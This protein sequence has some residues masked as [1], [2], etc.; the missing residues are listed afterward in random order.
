MVDINCNP[1]C[2]PNEAQP[3]PGVNA[4]CVTC[5]DGGAGGAAGADVEQLVLCDIDAEGNLLGT[6]IAV[7]EYDAAGNPV[8]APT[9]VDPVTGAVY[10]PQGTLQ[11]CPTG[12]CGGPLQF[13]FTSTATGPVAHPGR[14]YTAELP[15]NPGFALDSL[16]IDGT[17]YPANIQWLVTDPDGAQFATQ[18]ANFIG[19]RFPT[20]VV[21]VANPNAGTPVCGVAQPMQVDI[22]CIRIDAP[23][24]QI[25]SFQYNGGRDAI[26]N[27]AYLT[28]P[29]TDLS[30]GQFHYLRRQDAGGTLN[31][32]NTPNRGWETNDLGD[33][34]RDF[35]IWGNGPGGLATIQDT[36]P[37]PRGT[38]VQEIT[39]DINDTGPGPTI[40]QTFEVLAAGTFN[41]VLVHGARDAGEQHTIR[42]ST[43][44][45]DDVG[46]GDLINNVTFPPQVTNAGGGTPGAWTSFEQ[47]IF[48]NPGIYTF[49]FTTTNPVGPNRGGLFTDMRAFVDAPN[50]VVT[51]DNF[52]DCVIETEE[53]TSTTVCQWWQPQC[54][55]GV[56]VGWRNAETGQVMTNAAFWGQAPS[57]ECCASAGGG[58]GGNTIT[59]GNMVHNYEVCGVVG[60]IPRT[61]QRVV[62]QDQSGGVVADAFIGADGGPVAPTSW[63]MGACPVARIAE[64][65]QYDTA[66]VPICFSPDG[67][68]PATTWWTYERVRFNNDTSAEVSRVR[69]WYDPIAGVD[70]TATP[71]GVAVPCS[72]SGVQVVES[73][74]MGCA[75]GVPWSR[76]RTGFFDN[77]GALLA[78]VYTFVDSDG[79]E[80]PAAPVGFTLGAC[81]NVAEV[82][83]TTVQ[84][85]TGAPVSI[86]PA[87]DL[88]SWTVRNRD[89]TTAT[90]Q[91][92]AGA[93]LLLDNGETISSGGFNED[94]GRLND[95]IAV[96][97]GDGTV[98]VTT[99][100]R[101]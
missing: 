32:T 12:D 85:V 82:F 65:D 13:C 67:I 56:I 63:T 46:P 54:S 62:I 8:G 7:Y 9:F 80:Q 11:P 1:G 87:T 88:V 45:T 68:A 49:S 5:G 92:N 42:L 35:E 69:H 38:P 43:G 23:A 51:A 4:P 16:T 21:S 2:A 99:V 25:V 19:A 3:V 74:E 48:L 52:E 53:E 30:V 90:I 59:A 73:E 39:A 44:D 17:T 50:Q 41:L 47:S 84:D 14:R 20:A 22:S 94:G 61:L 37:T 83:Q 10:V 96:D 27:P 72:G 70:Q 101:L 76:R 71:A 86:L 29:P 55:N 89:A 6:A 97:P 28:T 60:G 77:N 91:V 40:W 24:P 79:N 58:G 57:P 15:I 18:L 33:A 66:P 81:P 95:T 100:R 98:R 64:I 75:A 36:T 31:C 26:I 34:N 93:V 78:V